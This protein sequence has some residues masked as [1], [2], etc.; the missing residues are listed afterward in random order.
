MSYFFLRS[1]VYNG[2]N[3]S[4]SL[5]LHWAKLLVFS[6]Q[7]IFLMT[8][9]QILPE[10]VQESSCFS[11]GMSLKGFITLIEAVQE[12]L[13]KRFETSKK[14]GA[15]CVSCC[16]FTIIVESCVFVSQINRNNT[17]TQ[18]FISSLCSRYVYF[19]FLSQKQV[20]FVVQQTRNLTLL[21][22]ID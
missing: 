7:M 15:F 16:V 2:K 18:Q 20:Y 13:A 19:F 5:S 14:V 1:C 8:N 3:K 12:R 6:I 10:H 11:K 4:L 17:R 22:Q 9:Q 21:L